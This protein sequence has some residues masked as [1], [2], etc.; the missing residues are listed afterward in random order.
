MNEMDQNHQDALIEQALR[1]L[2]VLNDDAVE[3]ADRAAFAAWLA[4]GP[5]QE[6]AWARA[7]QVWRQAGAIAPAIRA[8]RAGLG[9]MPPAARENRGWS[10]RRW[11][12]A[13]AASGLVALAGGYALTGRDLFSDHATGVGRLVAGADAADVSVVRPVGHDESIPRRDRGPVPLAQRP[14]A[15]EG[16]QPARPQQ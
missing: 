8:Q 9:A 1:W 3:D 14:F 13:V 11:L 7:Q 2:V 6:A 4:R 16:P 15:P 5:A 12:G 10:R